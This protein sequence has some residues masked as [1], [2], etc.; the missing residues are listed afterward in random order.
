MVKGFDILIDERHPDYYNSGLLKPGIIRLG[1]MG[2]FSHEDI[3]GT[4]GH[5]SSD[6]YNQIINNL[7]AHLS[8]DI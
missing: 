3:E 6:T 2:A 5:I 4:L 8:K 1:F 7:I